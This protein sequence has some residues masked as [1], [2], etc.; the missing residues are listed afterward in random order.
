M[1]NCGFCRFATGASALVLAVLAVP[2]VAAE[3]EA[4]LDED[5]TYA[6]ENIVVVGKWTGYSV[7][8]GSTS[9]KTPT[10]LI[11]TP[12]AVT[13]VTRDQ[14]DD[15]NIRQLG[16]ALRYVAGV[17]METGEGHR[18]EIFIRGQ[19]TTS[20][21]YLNGLRDDAQY[22]RSLYDIERIEVL[23]GA[24]ALTFGRGGG[25]GIVNRVSKS[26]DFGEGFVHGNASVDTFGAFALATDINQ[27]L[28]DSLAGRLNATY[29]EFDSHRDFY[30]GRFFGISPTVSLRPIERTR[31]V[32]G[33]SYTDDQRVT[34]RGVPSLG[35]RPL[36]DYDKTFFG[37]PDF[38]QAS[39]KVH[40][41]R[42]R[43][44]HDVNDALTVNLSA[45]YANY[46]KVYANVTPSSTDGST[47]TLG[48]YRDA[49]MREN[50]IGQGNLVWQGNTGSIGH[51]L[52][53]GFEAMR[54]DTQNSRNG[55]SFATA[56]GPASSVT[57]PLART[58]ALPPVSLGGVARSR[59][60]QLTV[61]SAY[62]QDQLE[63]G[64]WLQ[65]VGGIRFESFDLETRD[66]LSGTPGDRRDEKWSPRFGIVLKPQ[67]SLSI[68][69]SYTESFLPQAGDQF[70]ILSPGDTA[71]DPEKFENIEAGIKWAPR[72]DLLVSAAVFQL[73]RSN[74]TAP[75]P[76]G[77]GLS[78]LTGKT[79]VRGFEAQ[80]SG[81]LTKDWHVNLGYT[82]L[83]GEIR[84]D[85]DAAPAGT[86]LQQVPEHHIAAWMRYDVTHR[87]GLGGGIVHS[88]KQFASF[89]NA[90]VLPAYTRV[91]A[92]A[93]FDL[94]D[95]V[96]LQV[97]I[98]NLFDED[99]YPSAHGDNNIQPAKPLSASFG[100][101]VEM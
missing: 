21:F 35:G 77:S 55:I 66:V 48:G 60:S 98:E 36:D 51:T 56:G 96:S 52:L 30:E 27:P 50:W 75:D 12:Q 67:E 88:S 45:Q 8:D 64:D 25:G 78:A 61:L 69:A 59:D 99:Y 89:S 37:D 26:A 58:I 32:L 74:T 46:D 19:E 92:A 47:V 82:Y 90:V 22:Y 70:L 38:N 28:S 63:I 83:D 33:Y 7:T 71:L 20:D 100:V 87:F 73:E 72:P 86:T 41:A 5:R 13:V 17:S 65:L 101:R 81:N 4:T 18:D 91:D 49:T 93:Y 94:T 97:N 3:S 44:D 2:A 42:M 79:R 14:L 1:G 85:T 11:D 9:M 80:V 95:R 24:N 6:P 68:Y 76:D 34:D 40:I 84:S 43:I 29:E 10:P 53:A 62:V 15:Q 57:V 23:K 16:E 31:I 54:Q 39:S